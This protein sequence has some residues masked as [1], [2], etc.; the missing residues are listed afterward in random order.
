VESVYDQLSDYIDSIKRRFA[1]TDGG[2]DIIA[3]IEAR[4]A[5]LLYEASS[6]GEKV[7]T[8][9]MVEDI[10]ERM[11]DFGS[12]SAEGAQAGP[13]QGESG[14]MSGGTRSLYRRKSEGK[15]A[16]VCY[17]LATYLGVDPLFVRVLFII[18]MGIIPYVVLWVI[19]KDA[20]TPMLQRRMEGS[21]PSI[22]AFWEKF[23]T[24]FD[25]MQAKF[26]ALGNTKRVIICLCV[27]LFVMLIKSH[28]VMGVFAALL[29]YLFFRAESRTARLIYMALFVFVL[30]LKL[31]YNFNIGNYHF[32]SY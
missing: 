1:D 25:G 29:T 7:V 2:D 22:D 30:V 28:L 18:F 4:I 8:G 11:G 26:K 16:G 12:G 20:D 24:F 5:E 10:I 23:D 27:G 17:G 9:K 21:H 31:H 15:V 14:T 3:D 19:L 32:Y 13:S 6:K